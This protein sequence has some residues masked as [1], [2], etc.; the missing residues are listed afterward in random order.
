MIASTALLALLAAA[1][2]PTNMPVTATPTTNMPVTATPTTSRPVTVTPTTGMPVTATPTTGKPV[3]ATPTTGKPVTATPTTDIPVTEVWVGHQI[4]R[5]KRRLPVYGDVGVET[6][7]YV[8]A[9]VYRRNGRMEFQ[10]T[11]CRVVPKPVDGVTVTISPA[12]VPRI[13]ISP[14]AVEVASDGNA[15]I[16]PYAMAWAKEDLD[17]DGKP[18]ATFTVSG[19]VCSGDVYVASQSQYAIESAIMDARGL[20][21]VMSGTQK[22]HVLGARGLCLRAITGDS[23]EHQRGRFA[24]IPAPPQTTCQS[25]AGKP[26]PVKVQVKTRRIVMP[27]PRRIGPPSAPPPAPPP[28]PRSGAARP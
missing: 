14:M 22:Q 19:T 27:A 7:N 15:K 4:L 25:L 6:Q 5:G 23:T 17:G 2:P 26:W 21:G 3:T 13:P 28:K 11:L 10:Q 12:A 1:T 18:G 8:L 9:R 20:T 16:T 24:Y